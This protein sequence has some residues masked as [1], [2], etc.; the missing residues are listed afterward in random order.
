MSSTNKQPRRLLN[1]WWLA[2]CLLAMVLLTVRFESTAYRDFAPAF[3]AVPLDDAWIHFVYAR[4]ALLSGILHYNLGE[5]AAGT[6]S[7]LWVLLLA[8]PLRLGVYPPVAAKL[9]G[10]LAQLGLALAVYAFL[11]K[12][13]SRPLAVLGAVLISSDPI[14]TFAA[15]SGMEVMLY[16]ALAFGATAA[17]LSDR[18]T[19]TG[20]LAAGALIARPDG[21][22]LVILLIAAALLHNFVGKGKSQK[23]AIPLGRQLLWLTL[24]PLVAGLF[25]AYLNWRATGRLLPASFYIRAGGM[26]M[27]TDFF[28][29]AGPAG[30][31]PTL[32]GVINDLA[33]AGSFVGHPLQWMLYGFG[34]LWMIWRRDVRYLVLLLF[35]WLLAGLLGTEKLQMIGGTFLGNRYVVPGLPFLLATQL[36]GASFIA[37]LLIEKRVLHRSYRRHL[38]ALVTLVT[39]LL[40]IGDPRVFFNHHRQLSEEYAKSCADIERMQVAVGH[41]ANGQTSSDAVIGTFDAGAIAY[42]SGRKTVDILGLNT[43]HIAPLSPQLIATLDYLITYPGLSE[44]AEK[45]YL[46]NEV[47]RIELPDATAVAGRTMVVYR[48]SSPSD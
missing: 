20:W 31:S 34:L 43:P 39:L 5:A 2:G 19:L 24:P 40:L 13:T 16:A 29:T 33:R 25:W 26:E 48:V 37:E 8:L 42:F 41:W 45:A 11:K 12:K 17:L 7:L 3:T 21:A 44:E 30:S 1:W 22:I 14:N 6:T 4:N 36:L 9:L 38:P 10:L 23:S 15:L 46:D 35:P 32:R 18:Y 28:R 47:F 27:F